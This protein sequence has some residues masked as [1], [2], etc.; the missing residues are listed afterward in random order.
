MRLHPGVAAALLAFV[1]PAALAAQPPLDSRPTGRTFR[2]PRRPPHR[3]DERHG[4]P[5]R[6]GGDRGRAD[7]RGRRP[8][9]P[10]RRPRGD[11]PRRRDAPARSHRRALASPDRRRRLPGR[12]PARLLGVQGPARPQGRPGQPARRLDDAAHRRRR[13]RL[14][15]RTSTCARAIEQ[16]L[17]VGPRLTGAGHYLSI[18]GGGGDINFL[19]PEHHVVADG[20]I[21]DGVEEMRKAVREEIKYGSDWI[22]LLVTGAFMSAGDHPE[23]VHFTPRTR[24]GWPSRRRRATACR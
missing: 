17:F 18:T 1:L 4:P 5:R 23:D 7:R 14:L 24:C 2:A 15:R 9:A 11:R 20:R 13:R 3:R 12:P 10:R 22:K 16:G 8:R 6:G 19:G 21:V